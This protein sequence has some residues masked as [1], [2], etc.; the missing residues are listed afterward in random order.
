M[1]F[2]L[3]AAFVLV[4]F[5]GGM[6]LKRWQNAPPADVSAEP[7]GPVDLVGLPDGSTMMAASGTV[8]RALVDWL[9]GSVPGSKSFELGGELFAGRTA[10][11]TPD[12]LG[13]LPRL[14]AMLKAYPQVDLVA[15]G[16]ASASGDPRQ[17]DAL[18]TARAERLV[19]LLKQAG[20]DGNRLHIEGRGA[21]E[22]LPGTAAASQRNDRV[23]V[24]LRRRS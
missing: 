14:V 22:P 13:R 23:S 17:D 19:D 16:H 8:T 18:A 20:I 1:R 9:E 4:I 3:F 5:T 11:P 21:A 15:V 24:V 7:A 10:D 12:S 6:A 2:L